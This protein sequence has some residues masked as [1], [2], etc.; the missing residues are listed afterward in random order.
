MLQSCGWGISATVERSPWTR[1]CNYYCYWGW[2]ADLVLPLFS[3]TTASFSRPA[4]IGKDLPAVFCS[5]MTTHISLLGTFE[6]NGNS[7]PWVRRV[8]VKGVVV[9]CAGKRVAT[10]EGRRPDLSQHS[11]SVGCSEA[12]W[13]S[14][15]RFMVV[16]WAVNCRISSVF[17]FLA[18][19]PEVSL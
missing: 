7:E 5:L 4:D 11:L 8:F 3:R 13:V 12:F 19:Y 1:I 10:P 6:S 17:C 14:Q 18:E 15:P 9:A 16:S 2:R